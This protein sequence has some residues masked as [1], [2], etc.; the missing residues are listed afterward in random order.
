MIR[1]R[2]LV[3]VA[4]VAMLAFS[5]TGCKKAKEGV[6][7]EVNGEPILLKT[8]DKEFAQYKEQYPQLFEGKDATQR[9]NEYRRRIL[10]SLIDD[11]LMRQAAEEQGIAV[12][13]EDITK[14]IDQLKAGFGDEEKFEQAITSAGMTIDQLKDQ[15]REQM[16]TQKIIESLDSGDKITEDQIKAY[17]EK[18]KEQFL[19]PASK[20][21]SHILFKLEDEEGARAVLKRIKQGEDFAKLAKE[22]STDK[23]TAAKGGDLGFPQTSFSQ[24]FKQALD[25][26]KIG[27]VSD[28]VKSPL[29]WHIIKATEEREG[30]QQTLDEVKERIEQILTQQ[31][32][33]NSYQDYLKELREKADIKIFVEELKP[34]A[35]SSSESTATP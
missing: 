25:K 2:T 17:Y 7:A 6:A 4:L 34:E 3:A 29:G 32:R 35:D 33:A 30:R 14:Q 31:R 27:E 1:S 15:I 8:L 23:D 22:Y 28:L 20:R 16:L 12:T 24:D 21:A 10:D 5:A 18:N 9:E 11:E 13:E 19:I 26:L